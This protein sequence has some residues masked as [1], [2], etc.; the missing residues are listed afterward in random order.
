MLTAVAIQLA[1][2]LGNLALQEIFPFHDPCHYEIVT[3][4]YEFKIHDGVVD[5]PKTPGLGIELNHAYVD[6]FL[7]GD[8]KEM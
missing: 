1:S 4:P 5:V 2:C 8:V 7:V 6:P 3:D